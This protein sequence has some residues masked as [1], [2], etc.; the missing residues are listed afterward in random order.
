MRERRQVQFNRHGECRLPT[1]AFA[2]CNQF[3]FAL[4]SFAVTQLR[5]E[6]SIILVC[7]FLRSRV[8]SL[9]KRQ[10]YFF[11]VCLLPLSSSSE[12]F[13]FLR[14]GGVV[15]KK[16]AFFYTRLIKSFASNMAIVKC[17]P[18]DFFV[19]SLIIIFLLPL[20]CHVTRLIN[21]K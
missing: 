11:S 10:G 3:R 21:L 8:P 1:A 15:S 5:P 19:L 2:R 16:R 7:L 20:F 18:N 9:E 13:I 4:S 17:I 6:Q 14:P 12:A